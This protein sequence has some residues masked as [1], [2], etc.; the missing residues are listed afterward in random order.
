MKN[1]KSTNKILSVL[2][3]LLKGILVVFVGIFAFLFGFF[4]AIFKNVKF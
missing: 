1:I 2:A 4:K 3:C